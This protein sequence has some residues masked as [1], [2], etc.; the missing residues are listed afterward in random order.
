MYFHTDTDT[1]KHTK[2]IK[3]MSIPKDASGQ[4]IQMVIFLA[5]PHEN[6]GCGSGKED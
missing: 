4:T 2:L 1:S 6:S 5:F 3:A